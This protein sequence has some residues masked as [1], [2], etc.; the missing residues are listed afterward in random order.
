MI[1]AQGT[2]AGGHCGEIST[3]VLVPE[4]VDAVGPDV[5]VLAAGG[6]G[7]GRQMAAALALG[8][9]GVW[10]GSIWLTVAE[11][12]TEPDRGGEPARG[13]VARHRALAVDDGQAGAS[14]AHRVDRRVGARRTRPIRC[15]CRCRA[16]CSPRRRAGS[17]ASQNR[18]LSGF[19]VGQIVGSMN[20][21]RPVRDVIFDMVEEWIETTE[22]LKQH[23]RRRLT[24]TTA[25]CVEC[26][27]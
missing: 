11:A 5:P 26:A 18:E 16:S 7:R 10:T 12:D 14:A 3:M 24:P 20:S 19:P 15:R 4:V 8:A 9:Q 2:E 21:V 6:I 27:S 17:A 1:V 23:R 25:T 13:D 22:R